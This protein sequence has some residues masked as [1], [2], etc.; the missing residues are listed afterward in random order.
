MTQRGHTYED[1]NHLLQLLL[2]AIE[3]YVDNLKQRLH[4]PPW[5]ARERMLHGHSMNQGLMLVL[6]LPV[7]ELESY[8]GLFVWP[9]RL[10]LL[11]SSC[12]TTFAMQVSSQRR[13][14]LLKSFKRSIASPLPGTQRWPRKAS[15]CLEYFRYPPNPSTA[16]AW[17]K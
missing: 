5:E 3:M 7:V 13:L 9:P 12:C 15:D 10:V 6:L 16:S 2:G 14:H 1:R 17:R 11:L 4:V 8:Q